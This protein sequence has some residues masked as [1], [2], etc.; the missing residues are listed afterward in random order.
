MYLQILPIQK[1]CDRKS[2]KYHIIC[3]V[4]P[5]CTL[6]AAF[7]LAVCAHS[8]GWLLTTSTII[9]YIV[10]L[11]SPDQAA[12][13]KWSDSSPLTKRVM[14]S[15]STV[16]LIQIAIGVVVGSVLVSTLLYFIWP[17]VWHFIA[18]KIICLWTFLT[19]PCAS[20]FKSGRDKKRN[21]H[22]PHY[23]EPERRPSED[24]TRQS[25][26]KAERKLRIENPKRR[27]Q[28][29]TEE[30]LSLERHSSPRKAQ[31]TRVEKQPRAPA[32]ERQMAKAKSVRSGFKYQFQ[33]ESDEL[34]VEVNPYL[35]SGSTPPKMEPLLT[36]GGGGGGGRD[37]SRDL[38]SGTTEEEGE[39]S[40]SDDQ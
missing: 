31:A 16:L 20:V 23:I 19:F 22:D 6:G 34:C 25:R 29:A 39:H 18:D 32:S 11:I 10:L 37:S 7:L 1:V 2:I 33:D 9:L 27:E 36:G 40:E 15:S 4:L 17:N 8:G 24:S 12:V 5:C 30:R 3:S 13:R 35:S 21:R 26:T 28:T 14:I 38:E